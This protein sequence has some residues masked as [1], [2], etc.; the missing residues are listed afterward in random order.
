[1]HGVIGPAFLWSDTDIDS[2]EFDRLTLHF[3]LPTCRTIVP[4]ATEAQRIIGDNIMRRL[5]YG[6]IINMENLIA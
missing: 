6:A 2:L 4:L 3:E 5:L 1:M